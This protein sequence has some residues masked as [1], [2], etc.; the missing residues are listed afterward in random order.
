MAIYTGILLSITRNEFLPFAIMYRNLEGITLSEAKSN[1]E[2]HIL[3][4]I[5]YMW[6]RQDEG[7]KRCRLLRVRY[8]IWAYCTAQGAHLVFLII[9]NGTQTFTNCE[10]LLSS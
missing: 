5:I 9:L 1:R 7:I 8:V 2:K 3:H 6:N 10:S 4:G